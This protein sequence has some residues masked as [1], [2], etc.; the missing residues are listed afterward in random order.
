MAKKK[1]EEGYNTNL[2][3]EFYVMS[4]LHRKKINA[5]LTLGNKKSVD[6]LIEKNGKVITLDVKGLLE[7]NSAFP[8]EN[9]IPKENHFIV[10][11]SFKN[12]E[13]HEISPE[14]YIVPS[15]ELYKESPNLKEHNPKWDTL[16]YINQKKNRKVVNLSR[17]RIL[18]D[19]YQNNWDLLK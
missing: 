18:K 13:N 8:I 19:K 16:V 9:V 1:Q 15:L 3:S 6:I 12:I 11:V 5:M 7:K 2:A 14:C 10:F 17:L 4:M